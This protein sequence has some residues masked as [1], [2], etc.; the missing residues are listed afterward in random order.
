[1]L[2]R[3]VFVLC[4]ATFPAVPAVVRSVRVEGTGVSVP[5]QT[6]VDTELDPSTLTSDVRA[7]W[8]T[9][10]L[11]DVHV[12]Q[13]EA[14]DGSVDVIFKAKEKPKVYLDKVEFTKRSP[15]RRVEFQPGAVIDNDKAR[16]LAR[17]L[18]KQL[19]DEGYANG[20][21]HFDLIPTGYKRANLMFDIDEGDRYTVW[22]SS[23]A[24]DP[25]LTEQELDKT[26]RATRVKRIAW[27]M[28]HSRPGYSQD[29]VDADIQR[30]RSLYTTRGFL[31]ARINIGDTQYQGDHV[32]LTYNID[33]G[34]KYN[35]GGRSGELPVREIC[36]C[37]I[38][39][40]RHLDSEG[41]QEFEPR[42][43]LT[44][45]PD[46]SF[47]YKF[48]YESGE[49]WY[50]SRINFSGNHRLSDTVLR[51]A[52]V[53]DEGDPFD[54]TRLARSL[55]HLNRLGFLENVAE[56]NVHVTRNTATR[57]VILDINVKEQKAGR[58]TIAGPAGT[59]SMGG[60]LQ[61]GVMGRLPG[62]GRGMLELPTYF[63][64]VSVFAFGN[65]FSK[66]LPFIHT[67]SW[68]PYFS[69]Q[70]PWLAG[71][72]WTSG[73]N[74]APQLGLKGMAAMYAAGQIQGRTKNLLMS[75][76]PKEPP[77]VVPVERPGVE[78]PAMILCEERTPRTYYIRAG[79]AMAA[80][81]LLFARPF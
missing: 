30:L 76:T 22:G 58:W 8:S 46:G 57:T 1:M 20:R 72:P 6:K 18:E 13:V 61:G 3:A 43:S 52:L 49:P 51:Q 16:A 37:V 10:A 26:L 42:V 69:L 25:K 59:V 50:V 39:A 9:G 40:R 32:R 15:N 7:L 70:R 77:I 81:F 19:R 68:M 67:S 21:V 33:A 65:P 45:Q 17:D 53:L 12:E 56:R 28:F 31:D 14:Y 2:Y 75:D 60:P 66:L 64:S 62:W 78:V 47:N 44:P 4:L 55:V 74:I 23:F 29:A 54:Q 11:Q 79:V 73:F 80:E 27:G 24:G 63:A 36:A 5:L 71:Q 35:L 34:R 38:R 48:D 41:R